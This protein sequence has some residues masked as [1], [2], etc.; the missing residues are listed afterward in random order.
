MNKQ[1]RQRRYAVNWEAKAA[2]AMADNR[3]LRSALNG[4]M[5]LL[6]LISARSDIPSD[7]SA[8]INPREGAS[9]NHRVIDARNALLV[10]PNGLSVVN[11][12]FTTEGKK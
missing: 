10:H 6:S 4:L 2:E 5:G 9:L 7:V 11:D 8:M 12:S 3:R 1:E